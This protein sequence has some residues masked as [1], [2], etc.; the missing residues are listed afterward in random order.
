[1]AI[2][3]IDDDYEER[4]GEED[5]GLPDTGPDPER[6]ADRKREP[7]ALPVA[8]RPAVLSM[9]ARWGGTELAFTRISNE[10]HDEYNIIFSP[11]EVER[12]YNANRNKVVAIRKKQREGIAVKQEKQFNKANTMLARELDRMYK[13]LERRDA[14]DIAFE[15]G[16]ID[17][18]E[19]RK[20]LKALRVPS[21]SDLVKV[22]NH[23]APKTVA[24]VAPALP[25]GEQPSL[26]DGNSP[27][28]TALARELAEAVKR[29]D[30]VEIQ[31]ILWQKNPSAQSNFAS[32]SKTD[33][34]SDQPEPAPTA[35]GPSDTTTQK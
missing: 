15:K 21:I 4:I 3:S 18:K 27:Q 24:P 26:P 33:K 25:P 10:L 20:G 28:E 6:N 5:D 30:E 7:I 17:A 1:M 23:F 12:L 8:M 34:K 31:R 19:Y 13:D 9:I 32:N 35:A 22:A 16:A 29:G 14:L 11:A 2:E